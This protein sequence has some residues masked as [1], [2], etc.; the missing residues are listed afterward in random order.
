MGPLILLGNNSISTHAIITVNPIQ[1]ACCW[2]SSWIRGNE[3]D[4]AHTS[5]TT[6]QSLEKM[7]WHWVHLTLNLW[8]CFLQHMSCYTN[9]FFL[10]KNQGF[11][12][13]KQEN[14][15]H[16][17]RHTTKFCPVLSERENFSRILRLALSLWSHC[18]SLLGT[19][20]TSVC[21]HGGPQEI[22]AS[23]L[24]HH[25]SDMANIRVRGKI[26]KSQWNKQGEPKL[27]MDMRSSMVSFVFDGPILLK[28]SS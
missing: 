6:L 26:T 9:D 23:Y 11:S 25:T 3:L 16:R 2:E 27:M 4:S 7:D 18:L 19:I 5:P 17:N 12:L 22:F 21:H 13:Y 15:K 24:S 1:R 20:I 10:K 14:L 8:C 28:E